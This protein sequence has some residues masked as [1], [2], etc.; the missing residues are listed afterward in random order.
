MVVGLV[1]LT[2]NT[3]FDVVGD[4]V[5]HSYPVVLLS[6]TLNRPLGLS[7]GYRGTPSEYSPVRALVL[8]VG[9]PR[10]HGP[11]SNPSE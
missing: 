8:Q 10:R 5:G 6:D 7:W 3:P 9:V 11:A 1:T 2:F 4:V